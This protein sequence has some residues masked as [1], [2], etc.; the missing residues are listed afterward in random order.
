[1]PSRPLEYRLGR[2]CVL[3]VDGT[4]LKSI[5]DAYLR[6]KA[7]GQDATGPGNR[8][9]SEIVIRRDL[10]IEFALLDFVETQYLDGKISVPGSDPIVEVSVQQGHVSR[11]FLATMHDVSEEQGVSNVVS[12]QW[13][14]RQWGQRTV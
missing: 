6:L 3:T 4:V 8:S 12:S 1:M 5:T 13:Q 9:S 2:N 14:F 7:Q 10:E 11:V